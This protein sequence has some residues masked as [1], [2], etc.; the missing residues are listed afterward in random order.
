M[1]DRKELKRVMF[2]YNEGIID[3]QTDDL[4]ETARK[5]MGFRSEIEFLR[6]EIIMIEAEEGS[7]TRLEKDVE[8][9]EKTLRGLEAK[10]NYL[11]RDLYSR[12]PRRFGFLRR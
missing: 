3:E 11:R 6:G 8:S 7:T 10:L 9:K 12:D 4:I 1:A 5:A 2:L